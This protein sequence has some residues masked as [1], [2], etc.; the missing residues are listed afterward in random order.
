MRDTLPTHPF[1]VHPLTGVPLRAV[2][3]RRNGSPIWPVMGGSTP[4]VDPG[5]PPPAVTPP[6][7]APPPVQPPPPAPPASPTPPAQPAAQPPPGQ[8]QYAPPPAQQPP[9]P[10]GPPA[11]PPGQGPGTGT[12]PGYPANTPWREMQPAEQTAYWQHQARRHEARVK[13]MADYDDL[14]ARSTEYDKLVAAS[15]TEHDRAVA[16]AR[17]QGR[18]EAITESGSK[19]V[20]QWIRAAATGRLPD[21]SVNALLGGLDRQQ[22]LTTDGGVDTDKVWSYI[23]SIAP[24]PAAQQPAGAGAPGI[25]GQQP[26]GQT[27]PPPAAPLT[28]ARG[29]PDMGQGHP[30]TARP[31]G[32]EAGREIARKRFA[33]QK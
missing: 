7:A 6:P 31:T 11:Q 24:Q 13:E 9:P 3:L 21:E 30:G 5:A 15:Q 22:F 4:P 20:D 25:P 16:E 14:K 8:T 28:S 17:R 18:T 12:D 32:L 26:A 27:V 23:G 10:G 2:G 29:A 1:L 33:T 19:L